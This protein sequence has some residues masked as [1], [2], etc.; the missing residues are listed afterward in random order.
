MTPAMFGPYASF[1]VSSYAITTVVVLALVGWV[2]IDHRRQQ[3]TLRDF[4]A[5]GVSRRSD[6]A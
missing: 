4:E 2:I 1:I 5:K 3:A 6:A